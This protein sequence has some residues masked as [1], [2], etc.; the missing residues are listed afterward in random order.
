[1]SSDLISLGVVITAFG[2]AVYE[3]APGRGL[4][5][6]ACALGVVVAIAHLAYRTGRCR[7]YDEETQR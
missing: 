6:T 7:A 3:T 5:Y 1:M 2:W 4:V